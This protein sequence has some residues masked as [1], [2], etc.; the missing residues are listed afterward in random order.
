MS[1]VYW[2]VGFIAFA[3]LVYILI[4]LLHPEIFG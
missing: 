2:I 3:L 1:P 4:A